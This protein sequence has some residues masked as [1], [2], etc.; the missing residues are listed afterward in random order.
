[1]CEGGRADAAGRA[2]RP[3]NG[4][5][6]RALYRPAR[7]GD[8]RPRRVRHVR[9]RLRPGG[10][11]AG[12]DLHLVRTRVAAHARAP[13]GRAPVPL[14]APLPLARLILL[15]ASVEPTPPRPMEAVFITELAQGPQGRRL[16]V[17]DLFDT[18]GIRTTYGSAVFADH[19]P[20]DT[21]AWVRQLEDEGWVN[22]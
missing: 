12:R 14:L 18:A 9:A 6:D 21:A 7:R 13:R 11:R 19:V 17:K 8:P 22:V 15:G 16:A 10:R 3:G 1:L 4:E 5:A 2:R 20:T